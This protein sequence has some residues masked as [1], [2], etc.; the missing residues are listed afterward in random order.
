MTT[1]TT[2]TTNL[3]QVDALEAGRKVVVGLA[4]V[5]GEQELGGAAEVP[6][7]VLAELERVEGQRGRLHALGQPRQQP[8]QLGLV[9]LFLALA[10]LF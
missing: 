1:M 10:H 6:A 3:E 9:R 4:D 7:Q 8:H 2:A 5:G